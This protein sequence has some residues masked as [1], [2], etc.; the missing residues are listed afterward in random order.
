MRCQIRQPLQ[1]ELYC[2]KATRACLRRQWQLLLCSPRACACA[3]CMPRGRVP[4]AAA[5]S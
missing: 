4:T 1:H 5:A 3:S 2:C